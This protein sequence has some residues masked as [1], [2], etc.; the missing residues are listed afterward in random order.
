MTYQA[1]SEQSKI[2]GEMR[3]HGEEIT[4]DIDGILEA[5]SILVPVPVRHAQ[6]PAHVLEPLL[7]KLHFRD[8]S[9]N[10]GKIWWKNPLQLFLEGLQ[11][12]LRT[13]VPGLGP[14]CDERIIEWAEEVN[15]RQEAVKLMCEGV[16]GVVT[17][18]WGI[19][20]RLKA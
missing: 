10:V 7:I 3:H 13:F 8:L 1:K 9:L 20:G 16:F 2:A 12:G 18:R 5:H 14:E 19:D 15:K 17:E 4:C 11:V 6:L